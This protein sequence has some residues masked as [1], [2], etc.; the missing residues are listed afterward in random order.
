MTLVCKLKS[1]YHTCWLLEGSSLCSVLVSD[2]VIFVLERDVKHQLTN[3]S[4]YSNFLR[5][6]KLIY[7]VYGALS[8]RQRRFFVIKSVL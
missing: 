6:F 2:I 8:L 1:F 4:L 5:Y 7:M 3:F